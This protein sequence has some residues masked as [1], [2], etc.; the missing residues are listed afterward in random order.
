MKATGEK[1]DT[2]KD[3]QQ[4]EKGDKGDPGD[5][6]TPGQ[7]G[8]NGTNGVNGASGADGKNGKDGKDGIGIA[9]A[10][11]NADGELVIT[12]TDGKTV[13]LGKVVGA[14]GKDGLTP[15]IGENGNWWIGEK[16]TGVKAADAAVPA[17]SG[18]I[19]ASSPALIVIGSVAGLA[20]L[21][22]LG[23]ILYIVLKKKKSLV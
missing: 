22:N 16:D 6:G 1:G 14:D 4:G 18:N 13:N 15:F 23:L 20:L 17:G 9:K 11:I 2:G 21:G 7:N 19:S 10:E 3:G 5:A 8:K 12:Y